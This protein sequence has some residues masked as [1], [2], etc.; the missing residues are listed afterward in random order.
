[1]SYARIYSHLYFHWERDRERER[2]EDAQTA[3]ILHNV[4]PPCECKAEKNRQLSGFSIAVVT[5]CRTSTEVSSVL[6]YS[7]P[8]LFKVKNRWA[9]KYLICLW[10][11]CFSWALYY[12]LLMALSIVSKKSLI[13]KGK[14]H[15]FILLFENL[16]YQ[17]SLN[18]LIWLNIFIVL[19]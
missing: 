17:K 1:M 6:R 19:F 10:M 14:L 7:I 18:Y 12:K 5:C 4:L 16:H 3:K 2:L 13:H 15:V 9:I 11:D 8:Y